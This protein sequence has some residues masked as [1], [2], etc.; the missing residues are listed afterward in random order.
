MLRCWIQKDL[1]RIYKS[2]YNCWQ[3]TL[4]L[5]WSPVS[6]GLSRTQGDPL[7]EGSPASQSDIAPCHG[8]HPCLQIPTHHT[9]NIKKN[10]KT[11]QRLWDKD[12]LPP[13]FSHLPCEFLQF[14]PKTFY[15]LPN[16]K[17]LELPPCYHH[18]SDKHLLTSH[19]SLSMRP[20]WVHTKNL[21]LPPL[22]H[23]SIY[24][25]PILTFIML[26]CIYLVQAQDIHYTK[27]CSSFKA[28]LFFASWSNGTAF[29]CFVTMWLV[30]QE[31]WPSK[32]SGFGCFTLPIPFWK[33]IGWASFLR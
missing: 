26:Y 21:S 11:T 4:D 28:L 32:W 9:I 31:S 23:H 20:F 12:R 29:F 5:Q 24:H 13:W 30:G 18:H 22:W 33:P 3:R 7:S 19:V 27:F 14:F 10:F 16:P 15:S 2:T 8:H 6:W 17:F 1:Q 25:L